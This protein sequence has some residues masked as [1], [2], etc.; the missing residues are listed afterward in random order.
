MFINHISKS[1]QTKPM[2]TTEWS[3]YSRDLIRDGILYDVKDLE[4]NT[5][6]LQTRF[7]ENDKIA[8]C[9]IFLQGANMYLKES[10]VKYIRLSTDCLHDIRLEGY[11]LI[12]TINNHWGIALWK[13]GFFWDDENQDG[14]LL[15]RLKRDFIKEVHYLPKSNKQTMTKQD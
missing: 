12:K 7:V 4:G 8:K 3:A 6:V 13:D 14:N 2:I 10:M 15:F 9:N 5:L 11:Y 1:K